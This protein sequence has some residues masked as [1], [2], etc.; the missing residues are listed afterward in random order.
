MDESGR[1]DGTPPCSTIWEVKRAPPLCARS[2]GRIRSSAAATAC[3]PSSLVAGDFPWRWCTPPKWTKRGGPGRRRLGEDPRP[4]HLAREPRVDIVPLHRNSWPALA[5]RR[6]RG[7]ASAIRISRWPSAEGAG[8]RAAA[9]DAALWPNRDLARRGDDRVEGP[10]PVDGR[11]GPPR[12]RPFRRRAPAPGKIPATRSL[13][14][15]LWPRRKLR[16]LPRERAHKGGALFTSQIV[17]HGGV[18]FDVA[19]VHGELILP[20]RREQILPAFRGLRRPRHERVFVADHVLAHV[21]RRPAAVRVD[22][23]SRNPRR[24][25]RREV[26]REQPFLGERIHVQVVEGNHV[27]RETFRR[28]FGEDARADLLARLAQDGEIQAGIFLPEAFSERRRVG[29]VMAGPNDLAF[30]SGRVGRAR[31]ACA[32]ALSAQKK[33]AASREAKLATRLDMGRPF[34]MPLPDQKCQSSTGALPARVGASALAT[35]RPRPCQNFVRAAPTGGMPCRRQSV[36]SPISTRA[37]CAR[38]R[39]TAPCAHFPRMRC[40]QRRRR[41]RLPVHPALR[42]RQGVRE[43]GGRQGGGGSGTV[44]V[45]DYFGELVLDG[46]PRVPLRS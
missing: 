13:A 16:I 20:F 18:P 30:A 5:R 21:D 29:G 36:R 7:D 41:D 46:G 6:A 17:E 22:R 12:F 39:P 2:R 34:D 37:R 14:S 3:L 38:S 31:R 23:A 4:V 8:P 43:R 44:G 26:G 27:P 15:K 42:T 9:C 35:N 45:G 33:S 25:F 32:T 10:H 28:A 40:R 19:F 24:V 1:R 11:P